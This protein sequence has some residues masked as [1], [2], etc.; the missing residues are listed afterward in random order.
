VGI[1]V[2]RQS[3]GCP[4]AN[5][6]T[7][8]NPEPFTSKSPEMSNLYLTSRNSHTHHNRLHND[9]I[10][11][12]PIIREHDGIHEETSTFDYLMLPVVLV[13]FV[14]GLGF[15][16]YRCARAK[17]QLAT[18]VNQQSL[19]SLNARCHQSPSRRQIVP[20]A[21]PDMMDFELHEVSH[22]PPPSY[23][24][25]QMHHFATQHQVEQN[26][27]QQQPTNNFIQSNEK[28]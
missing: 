12:Y 8:L 24:E 7:T 22:P 17:A 5:N 26:R 23:A 6:S 4:S 21:R 20:P 15:I 13:L 2:Q 27:Q 16:L 25:S 11:D 1:Y 10:T 14:F 3:F 19:F 9:E 28:F 18:V